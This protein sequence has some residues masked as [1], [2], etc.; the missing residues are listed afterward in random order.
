MSYFSHWTE[1]DVI[2]RN[3]RLAQKKARPQEPLVKPEACTEE[4]D[5]HAQIMSH[6]RSHGWLYF[7]GSMAHKSKR[8]TGE[9]DFHIYAPGGKYYGIECKTRTGKLSPAQA[10][11][12]A[13]AAR[14][15]TKFYVIQS[16]EEFLEIVKQPEQI[17][18]IIP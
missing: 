14:L 9:P 11:V 2:A 8:T 13:M 17:K 6:C 4:E 7:H 18:E 5:L 10:A 16:M 3:E 15:G 12:H 1:A